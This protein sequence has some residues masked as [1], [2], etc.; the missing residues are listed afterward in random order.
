MVIFN[1]LKKL[2]FSKKDYKN[3]D[4]ERNPFDIL[5]EDVEVFKEAGTNNLVLCD[6]ETGNK[7]R[8]LC[9]DKN[10]QLN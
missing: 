10:K 2:F 6:R 9:F 4:D 8:I 5:N 1:K 7:V 3:N